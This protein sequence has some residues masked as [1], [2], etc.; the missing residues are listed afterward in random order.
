MTYHL[1]EER[2]A[3]RLD[4]LTTGVQRSLI[5]GSDL[6]FLCNPNNPTGVALPKPAVLELARQCGQAGALLVVDEAFV[7]FVDTPSEISVLPEALP[8]GNVIVMRSLTKWWAIPGLRLGYLVASPSLVKTLRALQ[9]PWPVNALALAVG[10]D[11][12]RQPDEM[13]GLRRR[14][15]V[16][17]Q[18]LFQQLQA[19]SGLTP[20]PTS[21]NFV[22]CKLDSSR[23]TSA[24]LTQRL[25]AHGLLIRNCDSFTGLQ[26]GRFI[27][28][29][30]RAPQ[31]NE[32]LLTVLH[33][34]L[35]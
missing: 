33:E 2:H 25:A 20:F 5:D 4:P 24:D 16:W 14:L 32:R 29:A 21:T 11:L 18:D 30:V 34:A 1:L 3:F 12:F 35:T 27:R 7:D 19:I 9:Q 23:I 15:R 26:P 22:L 10:V 31:E 17:C 28:I 13:S 6:V 8:L